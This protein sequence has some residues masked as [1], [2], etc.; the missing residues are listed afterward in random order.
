MGGLN[1]FREK[2]Q[3]W[4]WES[5][6]PSPVVGN[7][8]EPNSWWFRRP[9]SQ[10]IPGSRY[11]KNFPWFYMICI[12]LVCICFTCLSWRKVSEPSIRIPQIMWRELLCCLTVKHWDGLMTRQTSGWSIEASFFIAGSRHL[13]LE[14]FEPKWPGC[15]EWNLGLCFGG[16]DIGALGR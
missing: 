4:S 9:I 6:F 14:K 11:G 16:V 3:I 8:F 15:F 5:S 1:I 10:L 2:S 12:I 13:N 7:T